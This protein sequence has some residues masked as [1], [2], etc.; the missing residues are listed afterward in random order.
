VEQHL[1]PVID[2]LP[3]RDRSTLL[4]RAV[5][6]HLRRGQ[7][8]Y[9]AG[10]RERRVHVV[11]DGVLKLSARNGSGNETIL[12]LATPGD[13]VG[14]LAAIDGL[15][16]PLDAVAATGCELIGLDADLFLEIVSRNAEAA[17]ELATALATRM[18]WMCDTAMER[19]SS[20]ISGRLAGRLLDLADVLGRV[21]DG[22]VEME[23][24]LAQGDLGQLAGMCR[25][26]ACKTLRKFKAQGV[27]D[28]RGR[29]LRILRP[30]VLERI[31]C[32]GRA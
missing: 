4:D 15:P 30:D 31:R 1:S 8:L 29:K 2:A 28:Y 6:R 7:T 13:I 9:F 18:R 25:E 11:A 5:P 27:V 21:N 23:M 17:L 24:P 19:T 26:S 16:Q 22:A 32:A 12:G 20:E 3:E 10:E 14:D